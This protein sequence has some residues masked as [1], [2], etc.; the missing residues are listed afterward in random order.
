M[1]RILGLSLLGNW[2]KTISSKKILKD[3]YELKLKVIRK[4]SWRKSLSLLHIM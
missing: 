3:I 2:K 1:K 4:K